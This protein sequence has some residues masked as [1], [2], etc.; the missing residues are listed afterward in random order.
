MTALIK[1]V[2]SLGGGGGKGEGKK[3]RFGI[4]DLDLLI[5]FTTF[6]GLR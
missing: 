6:I 4:P 1:S 3:S 5:H 2:V